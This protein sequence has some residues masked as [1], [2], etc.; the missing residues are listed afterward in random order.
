MAQISLQFNNQPDFSRDNFF[1]SKSNAEAISI[2]EKWPN[3]PSHCLIIYGQAHC[4]KTHLA[5]IWQ[6]L[7][8]AV[9]LNDFSND[10]SLENL[11]SEKNYIL[12]NI[13]QLKN[14]E[15]LLHLFNQIK[16]AGNYLL[17]TSGQVPSKLDIRLPD[18]KSRLNGSIA[19]AVHEPDDE[20]LETVIMKHFSDRQLRINK[21]VLS[22]LVPRMER[23][24]NAA[25]KLV[26]R[27]DNLAMKEKRNITIPF[28]KSIIEG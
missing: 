23:S 12:E 25:A 5:H 28:V 13:E 21:N 20:L 8:G 7:S 16:N 14:E 6:K 22:Y 1:I 18:L 9:F 4:G 2:I 24:F 26:E 15:K 3:W 27:I 19:I 17:L 11:S 10:F